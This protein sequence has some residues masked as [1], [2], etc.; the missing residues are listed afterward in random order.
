ML[1]KI[2]ENY[3]YIFAFL[4][5][6]LL[7]SIINIFLAADNSDQIWEY[8][9]SHNIALGMIPYKD[10]NMVTLPMHSWINA[11]VLSIFKDRYITYLLFHNF[12]L[13]LIP[14]SI[15][16]YTQNWNNSMFS[17]MLLIPCC[18]ASYNTFLL[19]MLFFLIYLE[20][21]N[22]S[23]YFIGILLAICILVKQSVGIFLLIPSLFLKN[24]TKRKKRFLT[25]IFIL[26]LFVLYLLLT[27]TFLQ[28][29]DYTLL[30]L[31]D[32]SSKN[33]QINP[34]FIFY[35]GLFIFL[36][37]EYKKSKD[38][39]LLYVLSF[40][41]IVIPLFDFVH[42][43]LVVNAIII[44][45][46]FKG[47]IKI[48]NQ[49]KVSLV[50]LSLFVL[51]SLFIYYKYTD[52][53]IIEWNKENVFYLTN[54]KSQYYNYLNDEIQ[55]VYH[56]NLDREVYLLTDFAYFFQL[57]HN[58]LINDFSLT[59]Y[60]NTGYHGTNKLMKKFD[61]LKSGTLFI[62]DNNTNLQSN[63]ELRNYIKK[64]SIKIKNISNTYFVYEKK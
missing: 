24:K 36:I 18:W 22:K 49:K 50:F 56:E 44:L 42:F 31:I 51:Y 14:T 58:L 2:K 13:A 53:Y 35:I 63:R 57:D 5:F 32:F 54:T 7:F 25:L 10:F 38:I 55:K 12:L 47:K 39:D 30:G 19:V 6:T 21:K 45:Y 3:K 15:Y 28:C 61:A 37:K 40:S 4:L 23:D 59:L 48:I 52:H 9:F 29:I 33:S 46:I 27:K 60:G 62:I 26:I 34:I 11:I 20:E 1:K 16:K 17:F 43:L 8:G 41:T 64:K